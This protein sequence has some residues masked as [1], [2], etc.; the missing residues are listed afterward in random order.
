MTAK[1]YR[2]RRA[3]AYPPEIAF[4]G[5]LALVGILAALASFVAPWS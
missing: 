3:P 2:F 5:S 1:I 4:L